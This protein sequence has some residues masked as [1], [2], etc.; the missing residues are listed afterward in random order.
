MATWTRV[1]IAQRVRVQAKK[2]VKSNKWIF[3]RE[4]VF[5][6]VLN[7][8]P[9]QKLIFGHFWICK[10]WNFVKKYFHEIDLFDFTTFVGLDFSKFSEKNICIFKN[11][12]ESSWIYNFN[13]NK[14]INFSI[15]YFAFRYVHTK[16]FESDILKKADG[17]RG[18]I[19]WASHSS[20]K[21]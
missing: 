13:C 16:V 21:E 11:L 15:L 7:F 2:L 20:T 19:T 18:A 10:K 12:F 3:F 1:C 8:F 14:C 4:I 5:L 9:V 6:A 17:H